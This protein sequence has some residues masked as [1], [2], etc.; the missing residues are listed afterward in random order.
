MTER[1]DY[2]YCLLNQFRQLVSQ[3]MESRQF[4]W[5][6]G[7]LIVVVKHLADQK[8]FICAYSGQTRDSA[9]ESDIA[10]YSTC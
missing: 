2:D 3:I 1:V 7:K 5:T 4:V 6:L 10:Y 8:R 9:Y